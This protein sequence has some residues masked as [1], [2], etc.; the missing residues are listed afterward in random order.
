MGEQLGH[1]LFRMFTGREL[2]DTRRD[3]QEAVANAIGCSNWTGGEC[4]R[5]NRG[6][7]CWCLTG[8]RAVVLIERRAGVA[9]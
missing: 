9:S 8:A 1:T 6:G 7:E 3:Q 5:A 2:V 4:D